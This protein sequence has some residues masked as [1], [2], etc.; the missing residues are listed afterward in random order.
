MFKCAADKTP[1]DP[2]TGENA[3][4]AAA[5]ACNIEILKYVI[6]THQI[7]INAVDDEG[8]SALFLFHEINEASDPGIIV[9][10]LLLNSGI[11]ASIKDKHG[12]TP[13]TT[14]LKK[15]TWIWRSL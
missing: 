7:N 8:K 14:L 6:R 9:V 5:R 11:D 10:Q 13:M 15:E 2:A 1:K 3:L 4:L 12:K